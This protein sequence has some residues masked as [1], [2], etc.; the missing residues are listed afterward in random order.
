MIYYTQNNA[1]VAY[2]FQKVPNLV[3]SNP[4]QS[5]L[6]L[7]INLRDRPQLNRNI[8]F[9]FPVTQATPNPGAGSPTLL[10]FNTNKIG[11]E[12]TYM[13]RQVF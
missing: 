4:V 3:T 12:T 5:E 10:A 1:N 13:G 8:N 6:G 11:L 9:L 2:N 7:K